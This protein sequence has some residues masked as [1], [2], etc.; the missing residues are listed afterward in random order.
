M[1][2]NNLKTTGIVVAS[3]AAV[4]LVSVGFSAW[5]ITSLTPTDKQSINLTVASTTDNSIALAVTGNPDLDV[6]FDALKDDSTGDITGTSD[7]KCDLEFGFTFTITV[8]TGAT[9]PD[10]V[11]SITA[12]FSPDAGLATA[13]DANY[14]IS[15]LPSSSGSA[16]AL[17]ATL[18]AGT[19]YDGSTTEKSDYKEKYEIVATST[20]VYTVTASYQFAWGDYFGGKNPSECDSAMT[21]NA[22]NSYDLT[23]IITA[24]ENLKTDLNGKKIAS[25]VLTP[26]SK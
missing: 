25:L 19:Y 9:V 7:S 15:P 17:P 6:T 21:P 20:T 16:L 13:V 14:V 8:K 5:V 10:R 2:K 22:Y 24:L 26:V 12:T 11:A 1:K 23:A 18:A 4:A 3:L